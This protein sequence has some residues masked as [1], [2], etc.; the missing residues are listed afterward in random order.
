MPAH[1]VMFH[2]FHDDFHARGQGSIS[3][4]DLVRLI[5]QIGRN[6]ILPAGEWL[7]RACH[8]TLR[9]GEICLTFDDC[10]L[11]QYD[12]ALPVLRDL[13]LTAF[14]FVYSSVLQGNIEM[15]EVYRHFRM[16]G[17]ESVDAFY[18]A[19]FAAV[20][21]SSSSYRVSQALLR[22][23]PREYLAQ[24]P[25]YT[26]SDR[27][28]RFVRD[29]VLGPDA[30]HGVMNEMLAE[31]D[32]D[33]HA[34]ARRLWMTA[35]HVR[36]LHTAGHVIGLHSH[37]HPTRLQRFSPQQQRDE[38]TENWKTVRQITGSPAMAMSHPCNSYS[39]YTLA[40]LRQ[41]GVRV[42]FR[43]NMMQSEYCSLEHP[44]EDHA[45]LM[46][47]LPTVRHVAA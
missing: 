39:P 40:I 23:N 22:F 29:D 27:K 17:F 5:N 20:G 2:H 31:H 25:F 43:A 28:F 33:R 4:G 16:T 37:S 9:D 38:Y 8:N 45:N 19:F 26:S 6:R 11:C 44:R 46:A 41:L 32:V 47:K 3:A 42:G 18:D 10:L 15:L 12:V 1:G 35:D 24:F 34:V 13:D 30:Y 7:E 21:S 36:Q 14:F